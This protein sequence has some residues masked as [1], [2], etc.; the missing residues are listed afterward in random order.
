[1]KACRI[2]SKLQNVLF[3]AIL[4]LVSLLPLGWRWQNGVVYLAKI[5]LIQLTAVS[6]GYLLLGRLYRNQWA[7]FVGAAL[8]VTAPWRYD[9]CFVQNRLMPS[10][11]WALL[12]WYLFVL[13][14]LLQQSKKWTI[15]A[16]AITIAAIGYIHPVLYCLTAAL[17]VVLIAGALAARSRKVAALLSLAVSAVLWLPGNLEFLK[18]LLT[19]SVSEYGVPIGNITPKGYLFVDFLTTFAWQD[20]KPGLGLGVIAMLAIYVY[21]RLVREQKVLSREGTILGILGLCCLL[22]ATQYFPWELVQRL[23]GWALKLV[24]QM[25]TPAIFMGFAVLLLPATAASA[26]STLQQDKKHSKP[27]SDRRS[28]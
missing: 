9:L 17:T 26:V 27:T 14:G 10:L 8:Y 2:G 4:L 28:S 24:S 18:Y 1:M 7:V 13:L 16:A 11:A 12:P 23:G 20:G 6:G 19:D 22:L 25:E 21:M 15:P 3:S 5:L